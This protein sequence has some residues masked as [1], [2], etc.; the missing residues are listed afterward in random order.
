MRAD[1]VVLVVIE[2]AMEV[3]AIEVV[4]AV[5]ILMEVD[6]LKGLLY[7]WQPTNRKVQ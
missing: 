4:M 3:E 7:F 6:V 2:G 1:R 5:E